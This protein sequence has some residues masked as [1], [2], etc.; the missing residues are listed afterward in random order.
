MFD[1]AYTL[2]LE[3]EGGLSNHPADN[4]GL[5]KYGISQARYPREDIRGLTLGRAKFLTKRDFWDTYRCEQMPWPIAFVMFDCVFNH[6]P[7]GPI[8]WLQRA[9]G[10]NDDGVLGPKTIAAANQAEDPLSV[11]RD[12][13]AQRMRHFTRLDDWPV[14]GNGWTKRVLDTMIGAVN[15]N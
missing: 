15:E 5:T 14:F 7:R 9:I 11:A 8:R 13:L 1:R 3:N 10:V 6:D 12:I 2:L 4:G